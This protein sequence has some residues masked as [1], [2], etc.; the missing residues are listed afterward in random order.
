LPSHIC[1]I[2]SGTPKAVSECKEV[3]WF[4]PEEIKDLDMAYDHKQMLIDEGLI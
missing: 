1:K 3:K 2:K 4:N